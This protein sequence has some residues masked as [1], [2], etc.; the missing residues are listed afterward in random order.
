MVCRV[1]MYL[2]SWEFFRSR[3][4]QWV[5]GRDVV[6]LTYSFSPGV[7]GLIAGRARSF[8]LFISDLDVAEEVG[9]RL[10]MG[11]LQVSVSPNLHAKMLVAYRGDVLERVVV[12]TGNF[13]ERS[14]EKA[15]DVTVVIEEPG[16]SIRRFVEAFLTR[17]D[18]SQ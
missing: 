6:V 10:A 1:S 18:P 12:S 16:D 8:K 7:I 11:G 4:L 9:F 5:D 17:V 2:W 15:R 3:L 13:T 14:L